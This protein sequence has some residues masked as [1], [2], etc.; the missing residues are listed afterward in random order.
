LTCQLKYE[1]PK[2]FHLCRGKVD[3]IIGGY[4]IFPIS[5]EFTVCCFLNEEIEI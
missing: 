5:I 3:L 2:N 4:S 1:N